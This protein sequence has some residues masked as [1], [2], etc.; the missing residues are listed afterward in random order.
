VI[1]CLK[2]LDWSA[3]LARPGLAPPPRETLAELANTS[4]LIVGAGGSIG[5][6]LALRLAG[7]APSQLVFLEASES[8]LD[9]L[10]Q[11]WAREGAAVPAVFRLGNVAD[12]ALLQEIFAAHAPGLVFH[13]AAFKHVPLLEGQPLAAIENNIFGTLALVDAAAGARIILLSTDKAVA[14]ASVMGATKRVA[15]QIVLSA[16][17]AV[18]RLGNVLASRG[19]VAEVFAGQ[20]AAGGPIT[21]TDPEASRY[22]LTIDEAVNLLLAAALEESALLAPALPAPHRI[23]DLARFMARELAPGRAVSL[24]F[25]GLRPGD[26]EAEQFWSATERS[27]PAEVETLLSIESPVLDCDKLRSAL[28]RL[29]T[30]FDARDLAAALDHL[31][32]LVPDYKPSLALLALAGG[33]LARVTA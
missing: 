19:S 33:S 16:G 5:S 22:F 31:Q 26:K 4:I 15:E 9:A 30:A 32:S 27:R 24:T 1:S 25:M 12:G 7:L 29:R 6:A 17:G 14:P 10:Q 8:N 11:Q 21:V 23:V 2:T 3:F 20:I 28:V 18:L 13:A